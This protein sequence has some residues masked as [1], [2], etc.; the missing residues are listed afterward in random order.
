[1]S[2]TSLVIAKIGREV[3]LGAHVAPGGQGLGH[4][5][6]LAYLTFLESQE[7]VELTLGGSPDGLATTV[8]RYLGQL[9]TAL[10]QHLALAPALPPFPGPGDGDILQRQA[11]LHHV[12]LARV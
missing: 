2:N 8:G 12:I 10:V 7:A 9:P 3:A 5:N 4:L 11:T 1:M 6:L